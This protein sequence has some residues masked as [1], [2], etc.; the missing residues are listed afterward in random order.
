MALPA[1]GDWEGW[2]PEALNQG[3]TYH[4][5]ITASEAGQWLTAVMAARYNHSSSEQWKQRLESG[6]LRRDGLLLQADV[7]V[8]RAD[9]QLAPSPLDGSGGAGSVADDP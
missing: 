1:W 7:V 4:D 9:R 8:D 2:R 6:E 3:W 5:S